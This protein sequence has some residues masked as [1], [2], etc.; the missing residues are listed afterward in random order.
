M[1]HH[2][3]YGLDIEQLD[4]VVVE[5]SKPMQT[6]IRAVLYSLGVAR[7]R[8]F[9]TVELALESILSEPPN[10]IFTDWRMQPMSGYQLLRI[11]RHKHMEP[12]CF[13]PIVFITAWGTRALVNKAL[14]SGAH[15]VMVKPISPSV[16]HDRIKWLL[17]D[18]RPLILERSGFYNING[19]AGDFSEEARDVQ[20]IEQARIL[21]QQGQRRFREMQSVLER[22]F[23]Q[24]L[25]Q[26]AERKVISEV[27]QEVAQARAR[28]LGRV[29][30]V[31]PKK[32]LK[33]S[34][35]FANVRKTG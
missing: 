8:V 12:L 9:E 18:N 28:E 21:H 1:V 11:V 22:F 26:E 24:K 6:I 31:A 34:N 20:S 23:D 17:Q 5:D 4:V 35:G 33:K 2:A 3:A 25:D 13:I 16:I 32:R 19:E 29:G 30:K 7:V 27:E 15:M 10:V 14:R